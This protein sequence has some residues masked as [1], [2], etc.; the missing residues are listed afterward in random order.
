MSMRPLTVVKIGGA[1]L[2]AGAERDALWR[3]IARMLTEGPVVVVHG[4]GPQSTALARRLGHEPRMVAGR[5]VTTDLDLD[6]AA[7]TL[8][9]HANATVVASAASAGVPAVGIAALDGGM[10][11]AVRRPPREIDGETVDFGHVGDVVAVDVRL[12][13]LLLSDG[14]V[15]VVAP[16]AADAAGNLLNVN[17]DTVAC[18]LAAALAADRFYLVTETGAVRRDAADPAT[19]LATL[20]RA[21]LAAGVAEG[22]IS[23]GMRPKL[24]VAFA[25]VDAGIA[26][27]VVL[28]PDALGAPETG[29]RVVG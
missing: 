28:G 20:D 2:G 6:V 10:V 26:Q 8:R 29:T 27:V 11:R 3:G 9:G 17:A 21:T 4:G 12:L 23:G 16:L 19:A 24:D 1:L 5:R 15:P 13:R 22:W 7:Y 14:F 18:A 25:A